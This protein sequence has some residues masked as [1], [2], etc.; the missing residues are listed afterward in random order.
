MNTNEKLEEIRAL[1]AD[2]QNR[3]DE[4]LATIQADLSQPLTKE[5]AKHDIDRLADDTT[6][7]I[8]KAFVAR[9]PSASKSVKN[10]SDTYYQAKSQSGK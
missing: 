2:L 4:A 5:K 9:E 1:V 8:S 6:M 10:K 3:L 7:F